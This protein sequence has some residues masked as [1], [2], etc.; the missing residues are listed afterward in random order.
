M[1]D[2]NLR[3]IA[4]VIAATNHGSLLVN[5][6]DYHKVG[7]SG[8]GVGYQLLSTSA[9]DPQ[10]ADLLKQLLQTRKTNF[11]EGVVALDCGANIGTLTVEWAKYMHGWGRVIAIEAQERIF[12][13]LA[14]NITLNNCFNARALWA[15]VGATRSIIDVPVPDYFQ[16]SS[17]GSLE[18]HQTATTEFIGQAIDYA[19]EKCQPTQQLAID[20]L[21]LERLDFLKLDIE[22]MEME[23]LEGALQTIA[24][25]RP[26]LFIEKIKTDET[27]LQHFL[28]SRD[29]KTY[30][31]GINLL[32][33]HASDPVTITAAGS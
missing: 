29:Y 4:F 23:A 20:D 8:Y 32:A 5:R 33:I 22:G 7:D 28:H 13:A 10:E 11:G 12:Y 21:A 14:G 18:L 25:H 30:P 26:Q 24:R 17:F 6:H 27:R 2:A 31:M 15:A 1:P 19:K 16:P 3:P 9:F